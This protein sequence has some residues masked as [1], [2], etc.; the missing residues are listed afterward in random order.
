VLLRGRDLVG[1]DSEE[2]ALQFRMGVK[3][4]SKP[5]PLKPAKPYRCDGLRAGWRGIRTSKPDEIAHRKKADNLPAAVGQQL[6]QL[7]GT[8][9][10]VEQVIWRVALVPE[11]LPRGDL[12]RRR[13]PRE[14]CQVAFGDGVADAI[15]AHSPDD[16]ARQP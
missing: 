4:G 13:R 1:G 2:T 14:L 8:S 11:D 15:L 7:Y 5:A 16:L 10:N 6:E 12:E 3:Q 9:R